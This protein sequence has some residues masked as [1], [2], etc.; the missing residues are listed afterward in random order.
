MKI[1][2]PARHARYIDLLLEAG[3]YRERQR[4]LAEVFRRGLEEAES[5][6]AM[7]AGGPDM[8]LSLLRGKP[9][10]LSVPV[11]S[12]ERDRVRAV[13][14]GFNMPQAKAATVVF[15]QGLFDHYLDVKDSVT[16]K[17][18]PVFR[19]TVDRMPRDFALVEE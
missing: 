16:Y 14:L 10:D 7:R 9:L 1:T 15:L 3:I 17:H 2:I 11:T 12:S 18:D 13:A 5:D 19:K 4:A 8:D 6:V